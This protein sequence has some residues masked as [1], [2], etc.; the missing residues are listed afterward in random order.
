MIKKL[1]VYTAECLSST[2]SSLVSHTSQTLY[3]TGL[4]DETS[5]SLPQKTDFKMLKLQCFT[6]YITGF[7][8]SLYYQ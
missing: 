7:I 8:N 2:L 1:L 4:M 6:D 5:P 3:L